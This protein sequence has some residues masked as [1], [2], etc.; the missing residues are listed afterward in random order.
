MTLTTVG[1]ALRAASLEPTLEACTPKPD[2]A[3]AGAVA[4]DTTAGDAPRLANDW[5]KA[6]IHCGLS[7]E[8]TN[9]T[10]TDTVTVCEKMSQVL[11]MQGSW[12]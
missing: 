2:R 11:R 7:V 4:T 6:V 8:T 1:A 12:K 9:T 3:R 5:F 10:P